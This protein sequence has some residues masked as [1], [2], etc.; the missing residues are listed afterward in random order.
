LGQ[1]VSETKA[2]IDELRRRQ[3]VLEASAADQPT[4]PSFAAALDRADVAIIAEVKRRSPSRGEINAG[5]SPESHAAAYHAGGAAAI[6]VLTEPRHF[7][8][9]G[10]DLV[11]VRA[12]APV[13]V[14]RKDFHLDP[15]QL[16][17]ARGLGASAVLLIAR[18]LHPR[19]LA[20]LAAQ[21]Q[22]LSLEALIEVRT[23]AELDKA[24]SIGAAI[25]GVNSRDLETLAVDIT[26]AE[27]LVPLVPAQCVAIA[28]SGVRSRGD[29]E[30]LATSGADA[31]LVGSAL[32]AALDVAAAVRAL[33]GVGRGSRAA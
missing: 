22:A 10:E 32:S 23:E 6:S 33:T 3:R 28:E 17:E 30:R 26:V 4:P 5:L 2:R 1:I 13:P 9:S 12:A 31:V 20:S 25:I 19:A 7:G 24:L 21:A 29:V 15:I 14:L 11:A 18:S 16:V 8:G 27:R